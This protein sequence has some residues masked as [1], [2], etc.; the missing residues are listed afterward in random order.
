MAAPPPSDDSQNYNPGQGPPAPGVPNQQQPVVLIKSSPVVNRGP[1]GMFGKDPLTTIC[2]NCQANVS[3]S[4]VGLM[5][6][7]IY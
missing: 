7:D 4:H 5:V 3:Q 2:P 1:G 6:N